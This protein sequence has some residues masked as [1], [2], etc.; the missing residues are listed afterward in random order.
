MLPRGSFST[1]KASSTF[2]TGLTNPIA[3]NTRSAFNSNSVPGISTILRPCHS[4]RM[5]RSVSTLP[6]RPTN[7]LVAIDQ[8]RLQPSSC[9]L[10]VRSFIGQLG[11]VSG[12]FSC[13]GGLG[14]TSIC[15][16]DKAPWRFDVPTQSEPVSPP[17]ITITCLAVARSC[18][19]NTSPALT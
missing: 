18:S 16:T 8:S 11:Q 4:T 3:N 2:C 12:R 10:E 19:G 14:I 7:S 5:A 9:E 17:P 6:S 15:V 13:T 1:P